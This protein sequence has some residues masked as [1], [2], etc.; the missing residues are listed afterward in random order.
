MRYFVVSMFLCNMLLGFSQEKPSKGDAYFFEYAYQKA[1]DAYTKAIQKG[2]MLTDV[3]KLNLADAYFKLEEYDKAATGYLA[4]FSKDSIQDDFRLNRLFQALKATVN[5][6]KFEDLLQEK[7]T[8]F[9]TEFMENINFNRQILAS[10][11]TDTTLDFELFNL[12]CNTKHADFS[13]TFYKEDILFT[14]G[15]PY[16]KQKEASGYLNIFKGKVQ[17]DGQVRGVYPFDAIESSDFHRATPNYS[18]KLNSVFYVLSNTVEGQ[19]EYDENGKN[20]LAI[21]IQPIDGEFRFLWRDLSTSFYYPF[22]DEHN[23]RL[24]FAADFG[25]GYGGTDIY[26]VNTNRGTLM[27]APVNLGP[28]IN[29]PG[30]EIAPF[31]FENNM[32]FSSDVFYGLGGMDI[33]KSTMDA[34]DNFSIPVNLGSTINTEKDD[35]G[36]VIR[37]F[38]EGLLGYFSSNRAGGKGADDIYGFRVAQKPGIKTLVVKGTITRRS[39]SRELGDV[40]VQL[41]GSDGTLMKEVVSNPDGSY[42]LEIPWQESVVLKAVQ[43][44]FSEYSKSLDTTTFSDE[45]NITLD[46]DLVAYSDIVEEVEGQ[47]V[48]KLKKFYFERGGAKITPEIAME[49]DKVVEAVSL[50]PQLQLRIE[51]HTDSRGGGATNFRITQAR[52]DAIKAYLLS[53]G[54]PESSILYAIGYGEDKILNNCTNGVYCL[55]MLHKQNQRSLIVILNDNV[56]FN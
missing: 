21:G 2:E 16:G 41:S 53:K 10:E 9:G 44:G 50:F 55:E 33:Y 17:L 13:P 31:I 6:E 19:L 43:N 40:T 23:E 34:N 15:R 24:Y 37:D 47:K 39:N 3:Q 8:T 38:G 18:E 36:F 49:L 46:I 26:Y 5:Q 42:R 28:R 12:Q 22:Y 20:A 11:V 1:I 32:Y 4:Y 14:S 7:V 30:N 48:V 45:E 52:S 29:T 54:V 27:S 51:T 25:T 35:F 56:L